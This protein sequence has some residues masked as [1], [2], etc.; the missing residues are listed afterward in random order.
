MT[1]LG[2][3]CSRVLNGYCPDDGKYYS[4]EELTREAIRLLIRHENKKLSQFS[5]EQRNKIIQYTSVDQFINL[6][7]NCCARLFKDGNR[8]LHSFADKYSYSTHIIFRHLSGNL[9]PYKEANV[10]LHVCVSIS[11][12]NGQGLGIVGRSAPT[13][14]TPDNI[15]DHFNFEGELND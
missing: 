11:P 1:S 3:K 2:W 12:N 6:N 7:P 8:I 9:H 5:L 14:L 15:E 4:E 13:K 10:R